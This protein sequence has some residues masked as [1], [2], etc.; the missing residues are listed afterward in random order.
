MRDGTME[1]WDASY[2]VEV[3]HNVVNLVGT[4]RPTSSQARVPLIIT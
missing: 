3:Y 1:A 2:E 4:R